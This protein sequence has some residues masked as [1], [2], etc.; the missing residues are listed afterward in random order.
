[1]KN[2]QLIFTAGGRNATIN[3]T[4]PRETVTRADVQVI[5]DEIV[6][7]ALFANKNGAYDKFVKG[8]YVERVVTELQ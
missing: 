4:R 6:Q 5:A 3:V 7:K 1:M 8:Q 2:L